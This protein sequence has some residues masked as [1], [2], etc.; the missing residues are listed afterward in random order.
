MEGGEAQGQSYIE[1]KP[2]PLLS[3]R[4]ETVRSWMC[5]QA[6]GK[7]GGG[8]VQGQSQSQNCWYVSPEVRTL[9]DLECFFKLGQARR[10]GGEVQGQTQSQNR[11]H[12]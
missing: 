11:C 6:W 2:L 8:E 10:D 12:F 5:F 7:E 1:P 3:R 9:S 4:L